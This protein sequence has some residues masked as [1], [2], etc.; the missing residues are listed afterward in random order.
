MGG[1]WFLCADWVF[2]VDSG[3]IVSLH[4]YTVYSI[5]VCLYICVIWTSQGC[6]H[7]YVHVWWWGLYVFL[8]TAFCEVKS[9]GNLVGGAYSGYM[10]VLVMFS[11]SLSCFHITEY[12]RLFKYQHIWVYLYVYFSP[13]FEQSRLIYTRRYKFCQCCSILMNVLWILIRKS[14]YLSRLFF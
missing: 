12:A 4:V 8:W 2:R 9:Q 6:L 11:R 14:V 10:C 5:C 7:V 3:V 13:F 1:C